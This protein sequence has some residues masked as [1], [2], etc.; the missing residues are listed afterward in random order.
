[1]PP[2]LVVVN[3]PPL[4]LFVLYLS[5]SNG[6]YPGKL[7]CLP[8]NNLFLPPSEVSTDGK[9]GLEKLLFYEILIIIRKPCN[10]G[11]LSFSNS[12]M[13]TRLIMSC[14]CTLSSDTSSSSTTSLSV[15]PLSLVVSNSLLT[16]HRFRY[17]IRMSHEV[18]E[19]GIRYTLRL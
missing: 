12:K 15:Q 13:L 9:S 11:T 5:L 19:E 7:R 10:R 2:L 16:R 14:K 6:L 4:S 18:T 1:M 17:S 3:Q 8:F